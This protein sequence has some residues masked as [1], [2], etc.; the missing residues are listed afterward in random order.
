MKILKLITFLVVTSFS[1]SQSDLI[2]LL[3]NV[4]EISTPYQFSYENNDKKKILTEKDSIY[5]VSK[6]ISIEPLIV[7]QL[8]DSPFGDMDCCLD[9]EEIIEISII[10]FLNIDSSNY[11]LHIELV[12][13]AEI[14]VSMNLGGEI[15]DWMFAAN[16]RAGNRNGSLVRSFEIDDNNNITISESSWGRN[17]INYTLE[18]VYKVFH[19]TEH[20][21]ILDDEYDFDF[22][23][24][25]KIDLYDLK[26][27]KF[28][29]M[30]LCLDI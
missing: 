2:D 15:N 1:Y 28:E 22:S 25:N 19:L 18:A 26:E 24:E 7:N 10:G 29:L 8:T 27:G 9:F 17:N 21:E 14:L 11:L 3:D 30:K 6:L 20:K 4:D 23:E 16:G 13:S 12:P 5:L